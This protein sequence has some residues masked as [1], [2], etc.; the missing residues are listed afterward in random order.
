MKLILL[1]FTLIL[2]VPAHAMSCET[3]VAGKK[4]AL[5]VF[6]EQSSPYSIKN[7]PVYEMYEKSTP[8]VSFR[9]TSDSQDVSEFFINSVMKAAFKKL[10]LPFDA[11]SIRR[12]MAPIS[13]T[14]YVNGHTKVRMMAINCQIVE[15]INPAYQYDKHL[16]GFQ[17]FVKLFLN[18][19]S[20]PEFMPFFTQHFRSNIFQINR[21]KFRGELDRLIIV[22]LFNEDSRKLERILFVRGAVGLE[23]NVIDTHLVKIEELKSLAADQ[24]IFDFLNGD[25]RTP[26]KRR[27]KQSSVSRYQ[28][29]N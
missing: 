23:F 28:T 18:R 20:E 7:E 10:N 14:R 15:G 19:L 8:D 4:D 29:A 3:I 11:N 16:K 12:Q 21:P 13:E 5:D 22:P 17:E 26:R 9:Y 6:M 2:Q 27:S 1:F 24:G 25:P